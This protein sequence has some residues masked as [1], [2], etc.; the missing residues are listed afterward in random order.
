MNK[1][2]QKDTTIISDFDALVSD[3]KNMK[4]FFKEL[5]YFMKNKAI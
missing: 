1:L 4:V 2:L 5:I 3:G